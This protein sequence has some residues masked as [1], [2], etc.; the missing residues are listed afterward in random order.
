MVNNGQHSQKLAQ[1]VHN[2]QKPKK[3]AKK[4]PKTGTRNQKWPHNRQKRVNS[5][6]WLTVKQKIIGDGPSKPLK[7]QCAQNIYES[8][9]S[10]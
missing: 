1:N 4:N 9:H 6:K 10:L 5:Q 3:N 7:T 8:F 2:R